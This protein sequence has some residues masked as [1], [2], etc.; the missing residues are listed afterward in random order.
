[1]DKVKDFLEISTIHG[2]IH[3]SRNRDYSKVFWILIVIAGFTLATVMI[4]KSFQSWNEDPIKTTIE[5][6]PITEIVFP[7]LTVCP[8]KNTYTNINYDLMKMDNITLDNNTRNEFKKYFDDFLIQISYNILMTKLQ[9]LQDNDM[10]YNWYRG[11]AKI[12]LPS[13]DYG[14]DDPL[15][16]FTLNS[17]ASSGVVLTDYF[18]QKISFNKLRKRIDHNLKINIPSDCILHLEVE[19][20]SIG[21]ISSSDGYDE[22][23]ING[24]LMEPELTTLDKN[25]TG[26]SVNIELNRNVLE[27]DMDRLKLDFFPGFRI[28]WNTTKIGGCVSKD[29]YKNSFLTKEFVR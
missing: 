14:L 8:P 6:L 20:V 17:H 3:I 29:F 16:T 21:S 4:Q 19:K 2:L 28:E 12:D 10:Y 22:F 9:G 25:F 27:E 1:M 7:K 18:G 5:T 26:E 15:V 11:Y 23:R 24:E 13:F